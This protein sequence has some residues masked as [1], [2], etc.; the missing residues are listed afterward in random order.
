M[1][2]KVVKEIN[3]DVKEIH[4]H[5]KIRDLFEIKYA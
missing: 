5:I 2:V 4:T 1:N 3:V